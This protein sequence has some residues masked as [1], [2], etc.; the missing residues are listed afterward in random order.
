MLLYIT[1]NFNSSSAALCWLAFARNSLSV[2]VGGTLFVLGYGVRGCYRFIRGR[3]QSLHP[4]NISR[5]TL[6]TSEQRHC[7]RYYNMKGDA[8]ICLTCT[9]RTTCRHTF[10]SE[11]G[12]GMD[13]GLCINC[14]HYCIS[15]PVRSSNHFHAEQHENHQND[16][17]SSGNTT[18]TLTPAVSSSGENIESEIVI[19]VIPPPPPPPPPPCPPPRI[20]IKLRG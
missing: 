10:R 15:M 7:Q 2:L 12:A 14:G 13:L 19:S 1:T 8:S 6:R 9:G 11:G 20:V 17:E 3:Y 16:E 18:N 5:V 4:P